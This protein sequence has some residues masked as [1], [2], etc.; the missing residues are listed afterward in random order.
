[1]ADVENPEVE[2]EV[3]VAEPQECS[4]RM[5]LCAMA[6]VYIALLSVFTH[7]VELQESHPESTGAAVI[8]VGILA[9]FVAGCFGAVFMCLA[10]EWVRGNP[11]FPDGHRFVDDLIQ[12]DRFIL[13]ESANQFLLR[14]DQHPVDQP[15]DA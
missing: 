15:G 10:A 13:W 9:F 14:V 1:M 3:A 11:E 8:A 4:R 6:L 2:V 7:T 12:S 5:L